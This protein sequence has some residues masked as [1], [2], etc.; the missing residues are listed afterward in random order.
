MIIYIGCMGVL[1]LAWYSV[2]YEMYHSTREPLAISALSPVLLSYFQAYI[3]F[4]F[5]LF[6][7]IYIILP[8]EPTLGIP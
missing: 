7:V 8:E 6:Y 3:Y 4:L 2:Y 1:S 5:Y